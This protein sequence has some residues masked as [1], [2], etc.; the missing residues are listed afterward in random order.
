MKKYALL[1]LV[2]VFCLFVALDAGAEKKKTPPPGPADDDLIHADPVVMDY[3]PVAQWK[4][5]LRKAMGGVLIF[6]GLEIPYTG[7]EK[8]IEVS[9][10]AVK[11]AF[12]AEDGPSFFPFTQDGKNHT[13]G[14][15]F[16]GGAWKFWNATLLKLRL[17]KVFVF[18]F[19]LNCDGE[20]FVPEADG[21]IYPDSQAVLPYSGQK[22]WYD[23]KMITIMKDP[24]GYNM[25]YDTIKYPK[26]EVEAL[27]HI[28]WFRVRAGLH[29]LLI[30]EKVS[31]AC[32]AHAAYVAK[33][34]GGNI[35]TPYVENQGKDGYTDEGAKIASSSLYYYFGSVKEAVNVMYGHIFYRTYFIRGNLNLIGIG[36]F[37]PIS[38]F[39]NN[40]AVDKVIEY[41]YPI[42]IPGPEQTI[43]YYDY[44]RSA[45]NATVMPDPRPGETGCG[46][47]I[48]LSWDFGGNAADVIDAKLFSVAKGKETPEQI[49]V[50]SPNKPATEYYKDNAGIIALI[51]LNPLKPKSRYRVVVKYKK[52]AG[53]EIA[54][55]YFNTSKED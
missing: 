26:E 9:H 7:D 8:K 16:T 29:P 3:M 11:K 43:P 35:D 45:A 17:N 48:T 44:Y 27:K 10:G 14:L 12:K 51:P 53:E 2:S 6:C 41:Q 39:N 49:A 37:D 21:L 46:F 54:D 38:V 32:R 24:D 36:F 5:P 30:D 52:E 15:A 23:D 1:L 28:N 13:I 4:D 50:S 47:A 19:D 33:N 20:Y 31:A 22:F 18:S 42:C 25:D 40:T 34:G 55:W